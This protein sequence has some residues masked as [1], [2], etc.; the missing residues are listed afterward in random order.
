MG[1]PKNPYGDTSV[2]RPEVR[3][4]INFI[5]FVAAPLWVVLLGIFS[6]L[7]EPMAHMIECR[8][9]WM[10]QMSEIMENQENSAEVDEATKQ[11]AEQEKK[12]LEKR[13]VAFIEAFANVDAENIAQILGGETPD[14]PDD[15]LSELAVIDTSANRSGQ[16][17]MSRKKRKQSVVAGF[18]NMVSVPKGEESGQL[19][20]LPEYD[21]DD[22][23]LGEN[24]T[25]LGERKSMRDT[26][27]PSP[28]KKVSIP[29]RSSFVVADNSTRIVQAKKEEEGLTFQ[30]RV[31]MF[32]DS[33][34]VGAIMLFLTFVA[35]FADDFR[36]WFCP[37]STD[38]AFG[39]LAMV[40]FILFFLEL[41]LKSYATPDYFLQFFFWLDFIAMISL[42]PDIPF[43]W[44]GFMG[45]VN[46]STSNSDCGNEI[47]AEDDVGLGAAEVT[48]AS[49]AGRIGARMGRVIRLVR[50]FRVL[51]IYE[52]RFWGRRKEEKKVD[53][54]ANLTRYAQRHVKVVKR[55]SYVSA[56]D[57][58]DAVRDAEPLPQSR[59][60]AELAERT[61]RR[62]IL[63]VLIMLLIFDLISYHEVDDANA[64]G[65]SVIHSI[66]ELTAQNASYDDFAMSTF[67]SYRQSTPNLVFLYST[68]RGV[69][70][71][72]NYTPSVEVLRA[73]EKEIV[74]LC[75]SAEVVSGCNTSLMYTHAVFDKKDQSTE[76]AYRQV[77]L[78]LFIISIMGFATFVF[79]QDAH[80]LVI[81]P[82]ENMVK[83]VQDLA[84]N[85]LQKFS[86]KTQ[87]QGYETAMLEN[88]IKKI[89]G[90][91]QVGFGDAGAQIIAENM[92]REGELDPMI[93]GKRVKAIF[94]FTDIRQFTDSCEVLE[95]NVMLFVNE[96]ANIVH[97]QVFRFGGSANKNIGDAFLLVWKMKDAK[98]A[99][100]Y[101]TRKIP[102]PTSW[103]ELADKSL[104]S[105][106]KIIVELEK[107]EELQRYS[108]TN[109]PLGR[110]ML[111]RMPDYKL[112]MGF[113]L[114]IGWA[115]E[116]AIGSDQ[117]IDASYLSPHVN[118]SSRLENATKQYGVMIL[119][120]GALHELLSDDAKRFCRRL[121]IVTVKG[122]HQPMTL[123]TYDCLTNGLLRKIRALQLKGDVS[124][125]AV[126]E[127]RRISMIGPS[128]IIDHSRQVEGNHLDD[129]GVNYFLNDLEVR[130]LQWSYLA[131]FCLSLIRA[132][133]RIWQASGLR[134][135]RFWRSL[136]GWCPLSRKGLLIP[137]LS[138]WG[139]EIFKPL[140]IGKVQSPE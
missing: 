6:R 93:P 98:T 48:R 33:S 35:L 17:S 124:S 58:Q 39:A 127:D 15:S 137:F 116:G 69:D 34:T 100:K 87:N 110:Q 66:A 107:N 86:N 101:R 103:E 77:I 22:L 8:S 125:Q 104:I 10:K 51:K 53:A 41:V 3:M 27:P 14:K 36:L 11:R 46:T 52:L 73:V 21:E 78:T 114:H 61:I 113:G 19:S 59:V 5:D 88:C 57:V 139:G 76:Q 24:D 82:I 111:E 108:S 89:G 90:L 38:G 71:L 136:G 123:Y 50:L 55:A 118:L 31:E 119:F 42:L 40:V 129:E 95:E 109:D 131:T 112:R 115:I 117:K 74:V 4:C 132:C 20:A 94:G 133:R 128:Q 91:L 56:K 96:I 84:E 83:L 121:D 97:G 64:K 99:A 30:Q 26:S 12:Q 49:K 72:Y 75:C 45:W 16:N 126:E 105:F 29:P 13:T 63:C 7:S 65:V 120:S 140:W 85:P 44:D 134:R 70:S 43:I 47:F 106:L 67:E 2:V 102:I 54:N 28:T 37:E 81:A 1:L 138:T 18:M 68:V 92:N 80:Q 130:A 135:A 60:G 25:P 32:V 23:K 79:T 9:K 122:S 62:V